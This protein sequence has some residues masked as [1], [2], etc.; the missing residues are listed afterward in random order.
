MLPER[1]A[2]DAVERVGDNPAALRHFGH[3]DAIGIGFCA[4][5]GLDFGHGFG[6]AHERCI[7]SFGRALAGV[8]VGSVADAA[9]AE[10]DVAAD[11][12]LAQGFDDERGIVAD[13]A[14]PF[15]RQPALGERFHGVAKVAVL[16]FAAEDFVTDDDRAEV[17]H[18]FN[19]SGDRVFACAIGG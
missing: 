9:E 3:G 2:G 17:A 19:T 11:V 7:G 18:Y 15:E 1:Y 12:G 8:V 6:V 4:E 5:A 16:A 14:A 10:H 13:D